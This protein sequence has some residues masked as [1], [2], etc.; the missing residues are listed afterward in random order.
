MPCDWWLCMVGTTSQMRYEPNSKGE[1][2]VQYDHVARGNL[3]SVIYTI[4]PAQTY[5]CFSF[6]NL[7]K[8][9]DRT[10][11]KYVYID[12]FCISPYVLQFKTTIYWKWIR[13]FAYKISEGRLTLWN[14]VWLSTASIVSFKQIESI[15][16]SGGFLARLPII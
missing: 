3:N 8:K 5:K 1:E 2:I 11:N 6:P 13:L 15:G 16:W 4:V 10:K 14:I 7:I 9:P 12:Q